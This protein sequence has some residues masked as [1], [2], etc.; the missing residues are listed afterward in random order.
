MM[1]IGQCFMS[2]VLLL[3][4]SSKKASIR[5]LSN[6]KHAY[7]EASKLPKRDFLS[8]PVV[9]TLHF[10]CRECG[11]NPCQGTKIPYPAC[12]AATLYYI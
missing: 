1:K 12:Y 7:K 2:G 9:K 8:G 5:T 3:I 6:G 4:G 11:F 10:H